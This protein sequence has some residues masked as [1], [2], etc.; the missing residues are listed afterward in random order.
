MV[1]TSA[2]NGV[3]KGSGRYGA[4]PP[5][6]TGLAA[7]LLLYRRDPTTYHISSGPHASSAKIPAWLSQVNCPG[8]LVIGSILDRVAQRSVQI[9]TSAVALLIRMV[10]QPAMSS[11]LLPVEC[12]QCQGLQFKIRSDTHSEL[13]VRST[14]PLSICTHSCYTRLLQLTDQVILGSRNTELSPLQAKVL[15]AHRDKKAKVSKD[16]SRR[17]RKSLKTF[18]RDMCLKEDALCLF[19]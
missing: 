11:R 16:I 19:C 18:R 5:W 3:S 12:W 14:S 15:W 7:S 4:R 17:K 9:I 6:E 2:R 10:W 13:R 8:R 1:P